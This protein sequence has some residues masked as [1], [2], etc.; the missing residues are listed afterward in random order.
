M[1]VAFVTRLAIRRLPALIGIRWMV[2]IGMSTMV[3][4]TGL[5]VVVRSAW[6]LVLPAAFM[7]VAH[8]CIFPA[9]VAGGSGEFPH[10]YRGVGTTLMLAMF[11]LGNLVGQPAFG[12]VWDAASDWKLP[13][14]TVAF[15]VSAPANALGGIG[16]AWATRGPARRPHPRLRR[17]AAT[18]RVKI[19]PTS[20]NIGS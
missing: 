19:T 3:V 16:Y 10:R 20:I 6:H 9:V 17:A 8:A 4:A 11:D 18:S 2:L 12:A 5:L 14:F 15:S 13:G 7:G 1:L